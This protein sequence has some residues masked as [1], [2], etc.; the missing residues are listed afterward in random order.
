LA[1]NSLSTAFQ[2]PF[3]AVTVLFLL[4][5]G[6][7][8]RLYKADKVSWYFYIAHFALTVITVIFINFPTILLNAI[9]TEPQQLMKSISTRVKLLPFAHWLFIAAQIFFL[10]YFMRTIK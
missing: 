1:H 3:V 8:L 5:T 4:L 6:Y 9:T 7:W 10:S 2:I